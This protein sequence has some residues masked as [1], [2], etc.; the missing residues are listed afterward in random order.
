MGEDPHNPGHLDAH[1]L[2]REYFGEQLRDWQADA[3]RNVTGGCITII[4]R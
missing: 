4:E 3:G 2:V 1:P